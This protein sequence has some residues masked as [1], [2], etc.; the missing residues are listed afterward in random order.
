MYLFDYSCFGV[1]LIPWPSTLH[2][3]VPDTERINM[4]NFATCLDNPVSVWQLLWCNMMSRLLAYGALPA[5]KRATICILASRGPPLPFQSMKDLEVAMQS[6][7][8]Q[9]TRFRHLSWQPST[10]QVSHLPWRSMR[11]SFWGC[12]AVTAQTCSTFCILASW[13]PGLSFKS[14]RSSLPSRYNILQPRAWLRQQTIRDAFLLPRAYLY[15]INI[16]PMR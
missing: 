7:L 14:I 10:V 3:L 13:G 12:G 11:S 4:F 6:S 15:V 2:R 1:Y 5:P 16:V 8:D 9:Y